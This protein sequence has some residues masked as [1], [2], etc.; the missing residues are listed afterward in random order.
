MMATRHSDKPKKCRFVEAIIVIA[1]TMASVIVL[2]GVADWI[3]G[4]RI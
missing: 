4:L 1:F 2:F 3:L